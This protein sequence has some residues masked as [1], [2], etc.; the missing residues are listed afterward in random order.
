MIGVIGAGYIG[1]C[2]ALELRQR[3]HE[4]VL[5]DPGEPEKAAS[6]GNSGQF[7]V[8]EVVPLAVPGIIYSVPGWLLDPLGRLTI[9]WRDLPELTPWLFRFVAAS[10]T[11]R[12]KAGSQ[13]MAALCARMHDD[14]APLLRAA[15]G[16]QLISEIDCIKLYKSRSAWEAESYVWSF[17]T[18]AGL[19]FEPL[20]RSRLEQLE[21]EMSDYAQFG[22]A[23][24]GRKYI[25]NPHRLLQKF[26]QLF[27]DEGGQ[28]VT[29]EVARLEKNGR[30]VTGVHLKNGD[31]IQLSSVVVA[32]GIDSLALSRQLGDNVPLVSER[33][34]HLMLPEPGVNVRRA[35]TLGWA[36]MGISPMEEGLRLAGTVELASRNAPPN[37]AR[38][39]NLLIHARKLFP[40][41]NSEGVRQW[42]GHRPSFPDS[43]PIIDRASRFDNV[44]YAFGHGHM[45][46]G[47]AATTG[48]MVAA[49]QENRSFDIDMKPYGLARF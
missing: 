25:R 40:G 12:V 24:K 29:G 3:G 14:Y 22:V 15:D 5:I 2:C 48:K 10:R 46:V 4:V 17:R 1:V 9:R 27:L 39:H 47:W 19:Q 16:Q 38:A 49:I 43:L 30:D 28:L 41:L 32:A 42:M 37:F 44:I 8:D 45:G 20:N 13:A 18:E 7:A 11:S 35:C 31:R 36:G 23:I 21:P 6:Y 33:G 34:Y 26:T